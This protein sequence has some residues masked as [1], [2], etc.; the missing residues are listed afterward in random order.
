MKNNYMKILECK[1]TVSET[2][3]KKKLVDVLN[4]TWHMAEE[5]ES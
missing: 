3:K 2:K 5:R 1:N 4:C